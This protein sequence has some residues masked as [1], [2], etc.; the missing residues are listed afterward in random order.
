MNR[1]SMPTGMT[2]LLWS[3]DT[4]TSSL[5]HIGNSPH[6]DNLFLMLHCAELLR[7]R[8]PGTEEFKYPG[9][10]QLWA[11]C[12]NEKC[13]ARVILGTVEATSTK[14][15]TASAATYFEHPVRCEICETTRRSWLLHEQQPIRSKKDQQPKTELDDVFHPGSALCGPPRLTRPN[16]AWRPRQHRVFLRKRVLWNLS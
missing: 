3:A 7:A 15:L 5:A 2:W 11:Q 12:K 13:Q 9:K 1:N 4:Q 14:S 16:S 6:S 10:F 8:M